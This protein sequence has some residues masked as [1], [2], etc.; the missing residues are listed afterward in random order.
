MSILNLLNYKL[1]WL[2]QRNQVLTNNLVYERMPGYE[3]KDLQDPFKNQKFRLPPKGLQ[4][5]QENH[6]QSSKD[7]K[8]SS[9]GIIKIKAEK[10]LSGNT[11]DPEHT[12]AQIN[13]TGTKHY[14]MIN[15]YMYYNK[16][17]F[18]ALGRE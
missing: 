17:F 6:F 13:E 18:K 1:N 12:L 15:A 7:S 11:V 9:P 16:L 14:E 4:T 3:A 8:A 2:T 5:T 10:T